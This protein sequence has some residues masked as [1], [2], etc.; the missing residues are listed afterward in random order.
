[1]AIKYKQLYLDHHNCTLESDYTGGYDYE[2]STECTADSYTIY[3]CKYVGEQT[4]I[5]ENVHYYAHDLEDVLKE[6]I[7]ECDKVF[8]DEE[9]EDELHLEWEQMCE[10]AGL[11]EWNDDEEEY[12]VVGEDEE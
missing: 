4:I 2:M 5:S 1:M 11:I 12:Q 9:I 6:K 3:L 8:C 7:D 10:E